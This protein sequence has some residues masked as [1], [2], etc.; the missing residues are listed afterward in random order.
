MAKRATAGRQAGIIHAETRMSTSEALLEQLAAEGVDQMFGIPGSAMMDILD[1]TPLAGIEYITTR[2]EGNAAHMA[3]GYSQAL[4]GEKL[5]VLLAQNGPGVTNFVTGVKT[6]D[7]NH[8]P[9][10]LLTPRASRGTYGREAI[11]EVDTMSVFESCVGWQQRLEDPNR[12]AELTRTAFRE[13][14]TGMRPAQI[15]IPRDLLVQEEAEVDILPPEQYRVQN[16]SAAADESIEKALDILRDAETPGIITGRGVRFADAFDE[17]AELADRLNAPVGNTWFNNDSFRASH[18][19]FAGNLGYGGSVAAMELLS[20]ADVILGIGTQMTRFG[21]LATQG[22]AWFPEDAD[23]I[24]IDANPYNIGK[25]K[26]VTIGLAGGAKQTTRALLDRMDDGASYGAT[27]S[28]SEEI[29]TAVAEWK[30]DL[31]VQSQSDETPIQ[32]RR[33]VRETTRA[34]PDGSVVAADAANTTIMCNAYL[35]FEEPGNFISPSKYGP[36]GFGYPAA[37]GAQVARPDDQVVALCGDGGFGMSLPALLTAVQEDL[38]VTA[39]VFNNSQWGSE[40]QNQNVW[41]DKRYIATDLPGDDFAAI[42]DAAGATGISV[43]DPGNVRSAVE[44]GLAVTGPSVVDITID[45]SEDAML[46]PSRQDKMDK[47]KRMLD[48]YKR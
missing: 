19:H 28:R 40:K 42:A 38:P 32:P 20:D 26:P 5:P 4:N 45:G 22:L 25:H 9:L 14:C 43:E 18:P 27:S 16:Q 1:I 12:I 2:H 8:T 31:E 36:V 15:D 35:E 48:K 29:Q 23:I 24:Q 47:P 39:V 44:E 33:A 11:Q 34:I 17:V 30:Q 37:L 7:H 6:A 3:D 21:L 41:Y 13:A 10:I 46:A